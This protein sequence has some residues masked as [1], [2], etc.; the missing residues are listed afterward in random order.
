MLEELYIKDFA[1][2][3]EIRISFHRGLNIIT[4]ET[5]AGKSIILGALN[6][7]LGSRATTDMI[8][9]GSARSIVEASF[10]ISKNEKLLELLYESGIEVDGS[11]IIKREIT[12]EGKGRCFMNAQQTPVAL[13]KEAG[14]FLV[15][16][17]GQ[18][19]HQNILNIATHR[20]I[21][22]RYAGL[23]EKTGEYGALFQEREELKQKL[24]S[25]SLN[26]EEKNRRLEILSHEIK[27]LEEARL[28]D[29]RE[30]DEL[31][32]REKVLDHAETLVRDFSELYSM[33]QGEEG[34]MLSRLSY[35]ERVLEKDCAYDESINDILTT[36]RESY[37]QLSDAASEI[38]SRADAVSLD[39]EEVQAVKERIDLLQGVLRKYGPGVEEARRHLEE[40]RNEYSGIELS[41]EEENKLRE[42]IASLGDS[43][44][45]RARE[46]SKRRK[47][48][49]GRLE[50]MVAVELA[51]LGMKESRV[52][53]SIKWQ[54]AP[55][56]EIEGDEPGKKY[57]LH[58]FGLD[59]VEFMMG[60][61]ETL[62]PLKKIAS[63]GEMSRVMLALKKIIVESD[64]V[65]TM[66]FD[67]VDA[68][69]GGSIAEAVG[70]KLASL[71][72]SAQVMVIT[73]LHQVA[74]GPAAE[75]THY[76]VSKDPAKGT[77]IRRLGEKQRI[78]ELARMI[79][80][81]EIT[82]SALEH[83]RSLLNR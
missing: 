38:R 37:Y 21:L 79:G 63:G 57:V 34:S 24:K 14:R 30:L 42:R 44:V 69:V 45:E 46:I 49:A 72:S 53:V 59:V 62:R 52:R 43:L 73:H 80:G 9:A 31:V 81:A 5:G 23:S 78:E 35:V 47:E 22:D 66:I 39:P 11:L 28:D 25:V 33:M 51:D 26:E 3:H 32:V 6:L 19:E 15:D 7:L 83:A 64:P 41:S 65:G 36:I 17:H 40:A 54:F 27:E 74:A 55:D 76:V 20:S 70:V 67:E 48:A 1:L 77:S 61:G 4:G 75:S 56:G 10:D 8:K 82:E 50:E 18:N 13:L 60:S 2:I 71:A 58:S 12:T 29:P 16:I 68:G